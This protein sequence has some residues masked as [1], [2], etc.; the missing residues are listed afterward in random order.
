MKIFYR[1]P[2]SLILCIM[3]GAFSLFS[4]I[5]EILCYFL[6]IL[7][8]FFF[9]LSFIPHTK[10][11]ISNSLLRI[12][13]IA[14]LISSLASRFYFNSYF[15]AYERFTDEVEIYGKVVTDL[16]GI[17]VVDLD[18]GRIGL[19]VV[20]VGI[21]GGVEEADVLHVEV[22]ALAGVACEE[23]HT[24]VGELTVGDGGHAGLGHLPG[25]K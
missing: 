24:G 25:K 21:L 1:R 9:V 6:W 18:V 3:L 19:E 17:G 15:K 22:L 5:S 10:F 23:V 8:F 11:G 2:L 4:Q 16:T 20:L 12:V 13:I 7:S 14:F